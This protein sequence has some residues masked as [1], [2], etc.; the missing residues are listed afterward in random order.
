MSG[1]WEYMKPIFEGIQDFASSLSLDSLLSAI[2]AIGTALAGIE[3]FKL[4]K[5]FKGIFDMFSGK[6]EM[7]KLSLLDFI[8][9]SLGDV[10][11]KVADTT[12]SLGDAL[13]TFTSGVNILSLVAIAGALL[14]LATATEKLKDMDGVQI[15]KSLIAIG[16]G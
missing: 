10:G 9:K 2:G 12:G 15:G 3:I 8:K 16:A 14:I 6:K 11:D 1:V 13:K 7:P 4:F 5:K